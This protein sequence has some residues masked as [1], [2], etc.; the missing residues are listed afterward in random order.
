MSHKKIRL[1]GVLILAALAVFA[2]GGPVWAGGSGGSAL[3]A[4]FLYF[5]PI[6]DFGWTYEAHLGAQELAREFPSVEVSERENACSRDTPKILK[7]YAENGYQVI[8]CHSYNFG[9]YISKAAANYPNA[10]FMWGG[11]VEKKGPNT[12]IYFARMYEAKFLAGMVAGKVTK[13][14]G[15]GYAAALPS[16]DVIR[17]INAFARGVS[18]VNP[19]AK[20]HVEWVGEWYNPSKER[21]VSLSLMDKGC[22][23]LTHHSDSYAPAKAAEE[24]GV[25]Y[26]SFGSDMKRFAPNAYLTG[27]VWN[28][29]PVMIDVVK[30]LLDGKWNRQPAQ[31]WWYGLSKDAVRLAPFCDT[32]P[33]ALK[34]RVQ[35][36]KQAIID[37]KFEIFPGMSDRQLR[38]I[39]YFEPNVVG[40]LP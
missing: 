39:S 21:G 14:N 24:R 31:D 13:T 11:G 1:Y 38:E 9:K 30:A 17:N 23:I 15:I 3:K 35:A 5:G 27:T 18:L 36:K 8:F 33:S 10:V 19:D 6:G 29:A 12:G 34:K 7:A 16:P 40:K 2:L 4:A 22:D 20:V 25:R 26:I 37:G 28:W 32:L